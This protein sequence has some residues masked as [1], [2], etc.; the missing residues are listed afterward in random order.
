MD[1]TKMDAAVLYPRG[2]NGYTLPIPTEF[3]A[4]H[5]ITERTPLYG[6]LLKSRGEYRIYRKAGPGRKQYSL[7]TKG[8]RLLV[9]VP[10]A[11]VREA[12]GERTVAVGYDNDDE[13]LVIVPQEGQR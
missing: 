4:L 6:C 2:K 12:G 13:A 10:P 1:V 11:F 9:N 3:V 5:R 8:S 7:A